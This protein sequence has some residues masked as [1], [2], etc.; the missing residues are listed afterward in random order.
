MSD[1]H[2]ATG[3][4]CGGAGGDCGCGGA[5]AEGASS[6]LVPPRAA[7]RGRPCNSSSGCDRDVGDRGRGASALNWGLLHS[8]ANP[9][10]DAFWR[11]AHI[12]TIYERATGIPL[13]GAMS[14]AIASLPQDASVLGHA[15]LG[16]PILDSRDWADDSAREEEASASVQV[17]KSNV[18]TR[19][20]VPSWTFPWADPQG[21]AGFNSVVAGSGFAGGSGAAPAGIPQYR[22]GGPPIVGYSMCWLRSGAYYGDRVHC[23]NWSCK[24]GMCVVN[25]KKDGCDCKRVPDGAFGTDVPPGGVWWAG[26]CHA[27]AVY[28]RV[29]GKPTKGGNRQDELPGTEHWGGWVPGNPGSSRRPGDLGASRTKNTQVL[30]TLDKKGHADFYMAGVRVEVVFVRHGDPMGCSWGMEI[31]EPIV[32]SWQHMNSQGKVVETVLGRLGKGRDE[33]P[34]NE[35]VT[36]IE[37]PGGTSVL[38][39]YDIPGVYQ[40]QRGARYHVTGELT[41]WLRGSDGSYAQDVLVL[42][43][44]VD[45][46]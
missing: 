8:R 41:A 42:D 3:A 22:P 37:T 13:S 31:T 25:A 7:S 29:S 24:P 6:A 45:G 43:D 44:W 33:P 35:D 10:M 9:S 16:A 26:D 23:D 36:N 28:F 15:V 14:A 11:Q 19:S 2:G 20:G 1:D 27:V 17:G 18:E 5:C 40:L 21:F 30:L 32:V 34:Q 38:I 12:G 46:V 4:S 39:V